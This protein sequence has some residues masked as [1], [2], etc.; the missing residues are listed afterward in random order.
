MLGLVLLGGGCSGADQGPPPEPAREGEELYTMS[1]GPCGED[2]WDYRLFLNPEDVVELRAYDMHGVYVGR[3]Q[4]DLQLETRIELL[5]QMGSALDGLDSGEIS[6]EPDPDCTTLAE[7][8]VTLTLG[9]YELSYV[10]RCP[11]LGLEGL[12]TLVELLLIDVLNCENSSRLAPHVG[13]EL[14]T[15]WG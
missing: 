1:P 13:C 10:S 4:A 15:P 7:S 2:C 6:T 12:D 14:L 5:A 11:P 8:S 9:A 3:S